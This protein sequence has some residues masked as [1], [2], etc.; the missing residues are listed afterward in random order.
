MDF[1]LTDEQLGIR[2]AVAGLCRD[3][4]H[5]YWTE[6]DHDREY[7]EE[8]VDALGAAGWLSLLV[9]DS[10]YSVR[11]ARSPSRCPAS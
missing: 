6:K 4:P 11:R 10:W 9:P 2:D 1:R 7:P 3:F 5:G 8:F